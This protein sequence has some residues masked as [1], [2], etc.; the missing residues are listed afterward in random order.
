MGQIREYFQ[1]KVTQT[2]VRLSTKLMESSIAGQPAMLYAPRS[3]G[4]QDY[5]RLTE[6]MLD[7]MHHMV[8]TQKESNGTAARTIG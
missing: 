7:R 3:A 2:S 1:E 8:S 4:A 6:E 5:A